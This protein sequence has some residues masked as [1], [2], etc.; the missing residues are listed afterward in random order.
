MKISKTLVLYAFISFTEIKEQNP[1]FGT[2]L[3]LANIGT[4]SAETP[5][6]INGSFAALFDN[7]DVTKDFARRVSE[8]LGK[9]SGKNLF[10]YHC[11]CVRIFYQIIPIIDLNSK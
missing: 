4:N 5:K 8:D 2:S 10:H 9:T 3:L 11:F 7:K 1:H 6:M